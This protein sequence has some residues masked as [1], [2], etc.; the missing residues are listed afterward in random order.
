MSSSGQ[1]ETEKAKLLNEQVGEVTNIMRDNITKAAQRGENI[2]N[3]QTATDDLV[4]KANIFKVKAKTARWEMWKK[5]KKVLAILVILVL[6][7]LA[8]ILAPI[9][10]LFVKK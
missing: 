9:I 7:V 8:A 4:S 1:S 10:N 5:D 3:L 2:D 6:L